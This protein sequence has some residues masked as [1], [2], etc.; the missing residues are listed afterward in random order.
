MIKKHLI[1]CSVLL[2]MMVSFKTVFRSNPANRLESV[3]E[4]GDILR[5]EPKKDNPEP[6]LS[7]AG[8]EPPLH[9]KKVA[10]RMA[11]ILDNHSYENLQ[12]KALHRQAGKWF[13]IIEPILESYNIPQD[14]KYVPLVESGLEHGTS[15][16]GA[17][18]YWQFMPETARHYGLTVNA[19]VDERLNMRKSTIAAAKYLRALHKEFDNWT[20]VAAAY[21][22]GENRIWRQIR[23]SEHRN[24][25][26]MKLNKETASYVYK[27]V[28][29]K[30]IIEKPGKYGYVPVTK[31]RLLAKADPF[32]VHE[33]EH[34]TIVNLE[35][36]QQRT[37]L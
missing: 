2:I 11:K 6:P 1:A 8:E 3:P 14:F 34:S 25:F 4:K 35:Q 36:M 37:K 5:K 7:F 16:K 24:Y 10:W 30:E 19:E 33:P 27:L 17:R 21:N 28:S 12:T 32:N 13:P 26:K 29:M 23:K 18:G 22:V 9:N 20:L 15:P 31:R